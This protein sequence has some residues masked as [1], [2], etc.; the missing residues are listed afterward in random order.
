[1]KQ[2]K[3]KENLL[4][5]PFCGGKAKFELGGFCRVGEDVMSGTVQCDDCWAII[6]GDT[7]RDAISRWNRRAKK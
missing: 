1:M 7:E 6:Y 2:S 3:T 5:C 4:L